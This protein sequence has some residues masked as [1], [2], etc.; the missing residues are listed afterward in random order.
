MTQLATT[1]QTDE[2]PEWVPEAV[3]PDLKKTMILVKAKVDKRSFN[4]IAEAYGVPIGKLRSLYG[5][6]RWR[7]QLDEAR[8][9]FVQSNIVARY[10]MADALHAKLQDPAAMDKMSVKDLAITQKALS[11]D[12]LN[13]ANGTVGSPAFNV[14]FGDLKVLLGAPLPKP[15]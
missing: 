11:D 13:L 3:W 14:S 7:Q 6:G 5:N 8:E 1:T 4:A 2:R 15:E 10:A 9:D 12:T